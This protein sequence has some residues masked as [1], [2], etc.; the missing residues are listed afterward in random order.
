MR[1]LSGEATERGQW[2][3]IAAM[4]TNEGW[5]FTFLP[6]GDICFATLTSG[7]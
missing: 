4:A 7:Q 5:S 6:N 2:N 1:A 3:V